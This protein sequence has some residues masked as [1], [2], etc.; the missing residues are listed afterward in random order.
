MPPQKNLNEGANEEF[1]D[2]EVD[3]EETELYIE[4]KSVGLIREN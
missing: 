3:L 1:S 4:G 2:I